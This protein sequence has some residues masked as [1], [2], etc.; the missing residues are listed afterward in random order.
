MIIII[1]KRFW[2][3]F[4]TAFILFCPTLS[5]QAQESQT[6][7][8]IEIEG[9]H[10]I[11]RTTILSKMKSRVG[12][13]YSDN[14]IN[15]DLKRIY[16]LG[17]FSDI[18]IKTEDYN[19]GI[20]IIISVVER[21][22]IKKINFSGF[23]RL[24][25]K[26]EKLRELVKTKEAQYL[27]YP[28]LNED[29]LTLRTMYV[30]KGYS[31]S[32]VEYEVDI[33][34]QANQAVVDFIA[35]E[36]KRVKIKRID[37][38]GNEHFPDKRILKIIKTRRAWLFGAGI[39]KDD[40]FQED[41][42]RIESFYQKH[43]FSDIKVDYTVEE[44]PYRPFL[45]INIVIQ[46]GK[47]YIIGM[48]NLVGN[49]VIGE[50]EILAALEFCR[51]GE[52]YYADG[53][54]QDKFIIQGLY[55]DRGYIMADVRTVSVLDS[56]TGTIDITYHITENEVIFV[57]K[58]KI[59]GNIKTKDIVVR[60]ELRLYPGDQFDG[61]KLRRSKERLSNLGFFEEVS[62]STEPTQVPNRQDLIV[63][64][65]EAKTGAFSFGGGYSTINNFVGFIEIEQRNFDWKNFPYFTG[66]GQNLK[67]HAEFGT[68][69]E[70]LILSF[71]EPWLFDYPISFG[72]DIYRTSHDRESDVG[73]AY[74]EERTG[75]D[76]RLGKEISEYIKG[77]ITYRFERIEISNIV[78]NASNELKKEEGKNDI[79]R[80]ELGL[81]FDSRDSV[82]DPTKGI[83]L[84][85]NSD[86][87]G[88]AFGGDKDFFQFRLRGSKYF[89]LWRNSVLEFRTRLGIADAYGDTDDIPI[90]ERFFAGGAYSI[91][92]Y[93]ERTV[94][95]IDASSDDPLGGNSLLI[96]NVEY[97]YPIFDFLRVACFYD[98]G[99]VWRKLSDIGNGG[100]K[101][102]I[103]FGLRLKTPIGPIR[104]DYG[105][106]LDIQP[107][108]DK[109]KSGRIHFSMG[110]GF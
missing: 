2:L 97:T 38:E 69:S 65:K 98:V 59:R 42:A 34:H 45:Y 52:V 29:C 23:R 100:F 55:F 86:I 96:G 110:G 57:D 14:I 63:E 19:Q 40:V 47:Q 88:G 68:V 85:G 79:S 71:T 1:K 43:G 84:T 25:L 58:I 51:S 70:N 92:G 108:E 66:D 75:G 11:S 27:D 94:G 49:T 107:G 77:N 9:N 78:L 12:S 21:A 15:D 39:F 35:S 22:L 101:S 10:S 109:K 56:Q 24:R 60:R 105:I 20:K 53:I 76:I 64:V 3:F 6:I 30:K 31:Q 48:I 72:F 62:Y 28:T 99:N 89:P 32:E 81:A 36:G 95:P 83:L 41:M 33:D 82:F 46:E 44:D 80:I 61:A 7:T 16:L 93:E 91:R 17:Y 26:E 74:D 13:T 4:L 50:A 90:Y 87:A 37:V 103:G 8:A 102:G 106:P 67:L 18:D 104:L 5:S 73:W 54:E